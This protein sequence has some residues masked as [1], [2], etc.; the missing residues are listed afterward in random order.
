MTLASTD[1]V[2]VAIAIS[3]CLMNEIFLVRR[4]QDQGSIDL[5]FFAAA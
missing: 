5:A 4:P 1:R 2:A 3:S